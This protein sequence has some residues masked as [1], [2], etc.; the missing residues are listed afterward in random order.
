M[1]RFFFIVGII[2]IVGFKP[3]FAHGADI[4]TLRTQIQEVMEKALAVREQIRKI[5]F[6]NPVQAT[7]VS[8][9]QPQVALQ[10]GHWKIEE[11]PWE[12]RALDPERQAEGGGK[13]EWEV[14]LAI[15]QEIAKLLE[16]EGVGVTILPAILPSIYKADVFVSIHADQNPNLPNA[17][18]FK[19]AA[20]AF[21]QSGKAKRLAQLLAEEYRKTT[22]L[23]REA[24]IP[25]SMPYYY[26]FNSKEFL[27]PVH[28][29]TPAV[30]I[31]TGYLPNPRDRAIIVTNPQMAAQGIAQGILKFLAEQQ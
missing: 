23:E 5:A 18:G 2:G 20:S 1:R 10:V 31:E 27:Y 14:N 3:S 11:A 15:A 22:W 25:K 28:P 26:A 30:I 8:A 19:V 7:L 9:S 13:M 29:T 21:D 16:A 6:E 24:Y 12:L 17:S 4:A